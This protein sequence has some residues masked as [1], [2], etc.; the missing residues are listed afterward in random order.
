[1]GATPR[2]RPRP[3]AGKRNRTRVLL[4]RRAAFSRRF[5]SWRAWVSSCGSSS[6][7]STWSS[8]T[9]CVPSLA[10][11]TPWRGISTKSGWWRCWSAVWERSPM[12]S[13]SEVHDATL[14]IVDDK[15]QNLRLISDFLAEHGFDLMLTR[16]GAQALDRARLATP[17]LV[18]LDVRM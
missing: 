12:P 5:S 8:R 13:P 6:S 3:T 2:R 10:G 17:D 15:P 1:S 11:R 4:L 14:L 18:L 16:S 7:R 9:P